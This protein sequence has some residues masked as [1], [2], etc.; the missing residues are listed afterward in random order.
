MPEIS[1]FLGI[2]IAMFYKD[3][4][5][6]HFNAIYGEL[7]ELLMMSNPTLSYFSFSYQ[8][9]GISSVNSPLEG[10]GGCKGRNEQQE[11]E[12]HPLSLKWGIIRN[13]IK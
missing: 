3:H 5:P 10:V 6:P 7:G 1:R 2:I 9:F 13:R 4:S 8:L 11:G 12:L